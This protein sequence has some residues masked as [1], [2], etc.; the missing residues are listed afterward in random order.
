ME[1]GLNQFFDYIICVT[2]PEALRLQRV[3]SRDKAQAEQ[4]KKRMQNQMEESL[5]CKQSDFVLYNDSEHLLID[6]VLQIIKE[7]EINIQQ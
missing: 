7:L 6:Q 2:A 1:S 4:V 5:K 3:I